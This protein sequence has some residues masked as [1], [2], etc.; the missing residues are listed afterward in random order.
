M[1]LRSL[2]VLAGLLAGFALALHYMNE[3][4]LSF[5]WA[6]GWQVG[7]GQMFLS[8]AVLATAQLATG[9]ARRNGMEDLYEGF[10]VSATTRAVGHLFS[11]V[12]VLPASLVLI[13]ATERADRVARCDRQP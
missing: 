9:R 1:L 10:P 2:V 3:G 11:L 7:Y 5:W 13:G 6:A 12:G 4:A 8:A